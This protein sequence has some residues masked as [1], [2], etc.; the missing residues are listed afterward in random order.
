MSVGA[1]PLIAI[2]RGVTPEEIVAIADVILDAGITWIEVPLNSPE[3][4]DSI[5]KL[6]ARV[7]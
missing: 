2:L 7:G 1:R 5:A 4:L 6:V 3:P